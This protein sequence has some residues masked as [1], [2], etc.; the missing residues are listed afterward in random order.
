MDRASLASQKEIAVIRSAYLGI[1]LACLIAL[2]A[3]AEDNHDAGLGFSRPDLVKSNLNA[4]PLAVELYADQ[5]VDVGS[6][7]ADIDFSKPANVQSIADRVNEKRK[8]LYPDEEII[9]SLTPPANKSLAVPG[10]KAALVKAL[11]WWNNNN[12]ATCYWYAQYQST[13]ATMFTDN[14]RTGSYN[15]YDRA[16]SSDWT[17]RYLIHPGSAATRATYGAKTLR[18]FKGAATGTA[19]TADVVMYFFN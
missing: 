9:L 3:L 19:A 1:A 7:V 12:C 15:V 4:G 2:P 11:F 13:V 18:G 17:F 10:E 8:A 6:L 5:R 14:V 16:G